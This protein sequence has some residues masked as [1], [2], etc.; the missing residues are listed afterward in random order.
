MNK[1]EY[2]EKAKVAIL[3][4]VKF[5]APVAYDSHIDR[6]ALESAGIDINFPIFKISN[7][8]N[9]AFLKAII[10]AQKEKQFNVCLNKKNINKKLFYF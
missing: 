6:C 10:L 2:I 1:K 5:H 9:E 8:P 4:R 7:V 3:N